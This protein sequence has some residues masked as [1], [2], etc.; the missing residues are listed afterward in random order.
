MM[1]M[2][3][4]IT[5]RELITLL[6]EEPMHNELIITRKGKKVTEATI[7]SKEPEGLGCLFG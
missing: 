4:K 2:T 6:I 5:V 7:V 3:D 1:E